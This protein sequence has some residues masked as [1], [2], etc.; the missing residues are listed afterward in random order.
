MGPDLRRAWGPNLRI[1]GHK[2]FA[3]STIC[4]VLSPSTKKATITESGASTIET[5]LRL[6][7]STALSEYNTQRL[8]DTAIDPKLRII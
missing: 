5:H 3:E 7:V 6:A 4:V 1:M 2:T 8:E